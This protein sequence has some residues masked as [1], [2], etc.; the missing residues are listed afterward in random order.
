MIRTTG[1]T[2]NPVAAALLDAA[3]ADESHER[4]AAAHT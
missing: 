4:R 1:D 2:M 3:A